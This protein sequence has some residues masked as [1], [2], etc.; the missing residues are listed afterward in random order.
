LKEASLF[1]HNLWV[2][3]GRPQHGV[4]ACIMRSTRAKYHKAIKQVRL[5]ELDLRKEK[6]ANLILSNRS[7]DFWSEIKKIRNTRGSTPCVIDG[8][9]S[10]KD[11]SSL[12]AEKCDNLYNSVS[13]NVDEM[14]S[15]ENSLNTSITNVSYKDV[16]ISPAAVWEAICKLK[17]GKHDGYGGLLSDHFINAG[18]DLS[19]YI[20]LLVTSLCFHGYVPDELCLSNVC[21][22]RTDVATWVIQITMEALLC[23]LLFV[24]LLI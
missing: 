13:F 10:E 19:V 12:F 2:L 6:F 15:L 21:L 16:V 9:S 8:I 7:R 4:V 11:I 1:P 18:F 5:H 22:I 23:L 24:R 20:N 3:A 17:L 14:G